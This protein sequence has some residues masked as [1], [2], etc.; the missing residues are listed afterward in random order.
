MARFDRTHASIEAPADGVV[1]A[2]LAEPNETVSPGTPILQFKSGDRGFVVRVGLADR[3][4][5]RVR[6]GDRAM[7][8]SNAWTDRRLNASVSE[9]AAAASPA[10]GTFDVELTLDPTDAPLLSGMHVRVAIDPAQRETVWRIPI[11]AFIEGDGDH[12]VV[13]RFDRASGVARRTP[14]TVAF[15]DGASVALRAGLDDDAEVVT[16]GAAWLRDGAAVRVL[17]PELADAP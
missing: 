11:D 10:T 13:Y 5:V 15:L 1:L 3:D 16:D 14:V 8:R 4:V 12:G 9:I 2:R 6:L 17:T 7:L